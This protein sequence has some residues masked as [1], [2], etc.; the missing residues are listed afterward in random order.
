MLYSFALNTSS[1]KNYNLYWNQREFIPTRFTN[2]S[3]YFPADS[4]PGWWHLFLAKLNGDQRLLHAAYPRAIG[5]YPHKHTRITGCV[6]DIGKNLYARPQPNHRRYTHPHPNPHANADT[7]SNTN[8]PPPNRSYFGCHTGHSY[9][10]ARRSNT[11]NAHS[12]GRS[13]LRGSPKN[14]QHLTAGQ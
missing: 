13:H 12:N 5:V 8:Q 3:C 9:A 2:R 7:I 14:H 4:Y 11:G 6:S 1:A 10:A